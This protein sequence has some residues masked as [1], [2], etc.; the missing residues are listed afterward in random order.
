MAEKSTE[1]PTASSPFPPPPSKPLISAAEAKR[2]E[3]LAAV[4]HKHDEMMKEYGELQ[5]LHMKEAATS[6]ETLEKYLDGERRHADALKALPKAKP[7]YVYGPN[8]CRP[9]H[10]SLG[11]KC[12]TCGWEFGKNPNPHVVSK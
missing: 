4:K 5:A 10:P 7:I 6:D 3:E 11:S 12:P 9:V 2:L 8:E 1:K